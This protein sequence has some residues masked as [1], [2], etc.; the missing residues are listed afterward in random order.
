M[1]QNGWL[2]FQYIS[3]LVMEPAICVSIFDTWF[4]ISWSML[5]SVMPEGSRLLASPQF[6]PPWRAVCKPAIH[7]SSKMFYCKDPELWTL[8]PIFNLLKK[9]P[10]WSCPA[11][12]RRSLGRKILLPSWPAQ[13]SVTIPREGTDPVT[14][15]VGPCSSQLQ[16]PCHLEPAVRNISYV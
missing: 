1:I 3:N 8:Q 13:E 16:S 15:T 7:A 4:Q 2:W 6:R 11:I 9:W 5:G 10:G 14:T 12:C